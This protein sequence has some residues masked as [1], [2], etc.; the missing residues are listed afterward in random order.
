MSVSNPEPGGPSG[1]SNKDEDVTKA[2]SGKSGDDRAEQT[3]AED[4]GGRTCREGTRNGHSRAYL[5][6]AYRCLHG[7]S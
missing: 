4:A 5:G 2:R 7:G 1:P 3:A 6:K